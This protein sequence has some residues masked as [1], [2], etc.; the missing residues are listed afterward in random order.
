M[1]TSGDKEEE[2]KLL[3]QLTK[4]CIQNKEYNKALHTG[5]QGMDLAHLN[6]NK[7]LQITLLHNLGRG[8]TETGEAKKALEKFEK[9]WRFPKKLLKLRFREN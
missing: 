1:R 3:A 6:E 4:F 5:E 7:P 2:F 9:V 8:Y